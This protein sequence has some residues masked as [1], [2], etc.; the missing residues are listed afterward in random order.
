[1]GTTDSHNDRLSIKNMIFTKAL[2]NYTIPVP[3]TGHKVFGCTDCGD[4]FVFES[5]YNDHINRRSVQISYMC[6]HCGFPKIFYNR[7]NLLFHIRSHSFKTA[8]INVTDLRIDPLPLSFYNMDLIKTQGS[9]KPDQVTQPNP[10]KQ[11]VVLNTCFECKKNISMANSAYK[12]RA[13]HFMEFTNE[14]Y[15]CPICL[16]TLPTVCGLKAHL[17][18]HLKSPPFYCPECGIHI[19]NKNVNYPYNHDCEG[20]K[21]IRATARLQ[22]PVTKCNLFHPNDFKQHMKQ[23]H[24]KKVYKC[25]FC[26]VACFNEVTMAKHLKIHNMDNKALIFY[27]CELCPGRLVLHNLIESHLGNHI[28]NNVYPCW[29]CGAVCNDAI[30][31]INHYTR[32]HNDKAPNIAKIVASVINETRT[33]LGSHRIYR[34]VKKC[35]H[36][37]RSFI[38]KCQYD[39]IPILP[40]LCPYKCTK[41]LKMQSQNTDSD[42]DGNLI[43]Y[44][45]KMVISEDWKQI[46]KH[47]S[48]HHNNIRCLDLK[49]DLPRI[50][51]GKYLKK[52]SL[53]QTSNKEKSN[54]RIKRSKR[55]GMKM[56]KKRVF[57]SSYGCNMCSDKFE[58]KNLL[59][60][61][62]KLHRDTLMAYQCMECGQSFAMKPSFSTHLLLEHKIMNVDDY[63]Q[64]KKCFNGDALVTQQMNVPYEEPF[65]ENQC[66]ICKTL[67]ESKEILEKH[68]CSQSGSLSQR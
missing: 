52:R 46:K 48:I 4:K 7:C 29:T 34:V 32:K 59:E 68:Q 56:T 62:L 14:T 19:S 23:T 39:E 9:D 64:N 35:D 67:F 11:C 58:N 61:H 18:L 28:Q 20:F 8:T 43:C 37:H 13:K 26:V 2:P 51:L 65:S 49:I 50:D 55:L 57:K 21:M 22:C 44:M 10:R 36:C 33:Q 31:L 5:S 6:R 24:L 40:N 30:A 45:C 17:R 38:Y 42:N 1:M 3:I 63:I 41:S 53:K 27:Q 16:F 66:K 15:T 25:Q 12:D 60:N 54:P 47:Y